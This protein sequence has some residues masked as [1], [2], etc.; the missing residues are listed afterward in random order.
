MRCNGNFFY[1]YLKHSQGCPEWLSIHVFNYR[2]FVT[3]F[4][5]P[6]GNYITAGFQ[7][8]EMWIVNTVIYT[9]AFTMD[10]VT[11]ENVLN[12]WIYANNTRK[13]NVWKEFLL[14]FYVLNFYSCIQQQKY[15]YVKQRNGNFCN[16]CVQ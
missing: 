12:D 1:V 13:K 6:R 16:N 2:C 7:V 9:F 8:R 4:F 10:K 15:N 11:E 14:K 3:F 5:P